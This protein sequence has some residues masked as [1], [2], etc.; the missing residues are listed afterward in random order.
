[1]KI[2]LFFTILL[3]GFLAHGQLVK[4]QYSK[5]GLS[6]A[7]ESAKIAGYSLS[8]AQRWLHEVALPKIDP[9]TNL[10]ISHTSGSARYRSLWNYDDAAADTY[11]FLFWAAYFTDYE[12]ILGPILEV[13]EA[14][15]RICNHVD[16]LPTVS[17]PTGLVR[18]SA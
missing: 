12:K 13:L 3:F 7:R 2:F 16:R 8:K 10:Y 15:Q 9:E 14:E 5:P 18:H 11:P 4:E 17:M 1:M 6:K